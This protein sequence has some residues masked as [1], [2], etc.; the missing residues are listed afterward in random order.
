MP[1]LNN[2][3]F[4][5]DHRRAGNLRHFEGHLNLLPSLCSM[6][7]VL[8]IELYKQEDFFYAWGTFNRFRVIAQLA[9]S[10]PDRYIDKNIYSPDMH[11]YVCIYSFIWTCRLRWTFLGWVQL[12]VS[13]C[14]SLIRVGGADRL[15]HRHRDGGRRRKRSPMHVLSHLS[16][17][18]NN[19][20][21]NNGPGSGKN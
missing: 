6:G 5:L 14:F 13:L 12:S 9:H 20:T 11:I 19:E 8:Q 7:F 4:T 18:S 16:H 15:L 1:A 10:F 17:L 2:G 3:V 21:S